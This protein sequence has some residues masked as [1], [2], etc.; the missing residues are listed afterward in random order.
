MPRFTN[1]LAVALWETHLRH[2]R[3]LAGRR[4]GWL[5]YRKERD[6]AEYLPT[7]AKLAREIKRKLPQH[8]E[9]DDLIQSGMVGLAE[10]I[11]R[12]DPASGAFG[13]FAYWRVRGAIY[14]A[15]KRK[16]YR[17]EQNLS[18]D[19]MRSGTGWLPMKVEV[20][21]RAAQD[22]VLIRP[23][24]LARLESGI[25][26]L[27]PEARGVVVAIMAGKSM[28]CISRELGRSEGWVR[29]QASLAKTTLR[30]WISGA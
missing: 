5:R 8:L 14:D 9:L 20:D 4:A 6:V 18:L 26:R 2:I 23:Q 28:A 30:V 10:A 17:E 21:Q 7:V 16:A 25:I 13:A 19:E 29:Q 22:E 11:Q 15:H 24:L 27:Q 3:R 1:A 12:Y